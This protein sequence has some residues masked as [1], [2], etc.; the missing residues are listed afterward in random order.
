MA[1][2]K[3]PILGKKEVSDDI[4]EKIILPPQAKTKASEAVDDTDDT[5]IEAATPAPAI[6]H[7][8]SKK[9]KTEEFEKAF[10]SHGEYVLPPL[11][12][13]EGDKGKPNVEISRQMPTSS[14]GHLQTSEYWWRRR[15]NYR[16]I[17]Y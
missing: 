15:D 6:A 1:F 13:L 8:E 4:D 12:L 10:A 16:T 17:C 2:F 7:V 11:S 5:L 3:K 14:R 9:S